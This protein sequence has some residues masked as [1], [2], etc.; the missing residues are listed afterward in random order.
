MRLKLVRQS[1]PSS[2]VFNRLHNIIVIRI[3]ILFCYCIMA[4]YIGS[5]HPANVSSKTVRLRYPFLSIRLGNRRI[6]TVDRG[7]FWS[8]ILRAH[9]SEGLVEELRCDRLY[10]I[11]ALTRRARRSNWKP[12]SPSLNVPCAIIYAAAAAMSRGIKQKNTR[13]L[14]GSLL[15]PN[16]YYA[17]TGYRVVHKLIEK[18]AERNWF[19]SRFYLFLSVTND[20]IV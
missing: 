10:S 6:T 19:N 16:A 12:V 2:C 17:C 18:L 1:S 5:G 15:R 14:C 7:L 4:P 20:C 3:R 8:Q 11:A 9:V 13:I